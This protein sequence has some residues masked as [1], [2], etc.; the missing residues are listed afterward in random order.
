MDRDRTDLM[1]LQK[2]DIKIQETK[3]R[4]GAFDPL[5]EEIEEPA[6][7]LET[8]LGTARTRLQEM[9][10]EERR[11]EVSS[12][13]KETRRQRLDE[14]LGSV[15]NLREEAAVSAELEMVKRALQTDEQEALTLLDQLRKIEERGAE[16]EAAY[17]EASELVEPKRQELLDQR[18]EAE[19]AL[20]SLHEERQQFADKI[21]SNELKVYDAIRAG[22]REVAVAGLTEDGACGHCFSMVPLQ[23]QNQIRHGSELIRCEGC[24]VILATIEDEAESSDEESGMAELEG[25]IPA[26][27]EEEDEDTI[28]EELTQSDGEKDAEVETEVFEVDE[29]GD[30]LAIATDK[31]QDQE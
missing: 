31:D 2:L 30:P 27:A 11:L 5:F 14:K 17:A 16:L 12:E 10:L 25:Q 29:A 26:A 20:V 6:L 8:E 24:G 7:I 1:E 18:S 3:Q 21:K 19:E 22:G 4:I 13:E 15:R 28:N 9:K 23:L